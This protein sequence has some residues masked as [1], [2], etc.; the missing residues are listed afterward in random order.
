LF[1]AGNEGW[2]IGLGIGF[3]IIVVVVILVGAILTL[4]RRIGVQAREAIDGLDEARVTTLPLWDLR[5][6]NRSLQAILDAARR[7]RTILR[8]G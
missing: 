5:D 4:A 3:A 8:E 7:A 1:V 6:T 2:Y